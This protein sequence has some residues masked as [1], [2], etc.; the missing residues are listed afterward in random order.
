MSYTPQLYGCPHASRFPYQTKEQ[1]GGRV[2]RFAHLHLSEPLHGMAE[3]GS[4]SSSDSA[5][6][7][8]PAPD[9]TRAESSKFPQGCTATNRWS[10]YSNPVF[11]PPS[12]YSTTLDLVLKVMHS[13][14]LVLWFA[15]LCAGFFACFVCFLLA[16]YA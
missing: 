12:L 7:P 8:L 4:Q 3:Q 5:H 15:H 13:V 6:E 11:Q 2:S 16:I 14:F 1:L 9:G 10:Q